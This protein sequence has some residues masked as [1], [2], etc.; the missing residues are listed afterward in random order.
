MWMND[1]FLIHF[2]EEN[3]SYEEVLKE[4]WMT[5][6]E[7]K[8]NPTKMYQIAY[9]R[10]PYRLLATCSICCMAKWIR[11]YLSYPRYHLGQP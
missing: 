8:R 11:C 10:V 2:K 7:F 3:P 5:S 1:E 9:L 6:K 4:W